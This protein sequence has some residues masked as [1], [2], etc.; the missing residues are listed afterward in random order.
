MALSNGICVIKC[1]DSYFRGSDTV[2]K[3]CDT[4]KC[5][6]CQSSND[7]C[8]SC[9]YPKALLIDI[10]GKGKCVD[11]CGSGYFYDSL[12][13]QCQKCSSLCASCYS[14]TKCLT[15]MSNAFMYENRCIISCPAAYASVSTFSSTTCK[16]CPINCATCSYSS[17][18]Q[19]I[20]CTTCAANYYLVNAQCY[21]SCPISTYISNTNC[22]SC[23]I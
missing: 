14:S 5:L 15:C 6:T 12:S 22:I 23:N 13:G 3:P 1:P 16:Q 19:S 21:S 10:N 4:T 11:S 20:N 9:T 8:A 18:D 7:N 17:T 2:C